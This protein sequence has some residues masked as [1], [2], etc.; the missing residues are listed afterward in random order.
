MEK[1]FYWL[2]KATVDEDLSIYHFLAA[3]SAHHCAAPDF[4]STDWKSILSLYDNLV[5]MDPSPL[6]LLNRAIALSKVTG[7]QQALDELE[8][9]KDSPA[10]TS[11]HLFYSTKAEF[12]LQMNEFKKAVECL[13]KAIELSTLPAEKE[14]LKKK[15]ELCYKK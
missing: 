1:G 13:E 10:L 4:E 15:L 2:E 6:I 14:L 11:Y 9:I 8:K 5:Q 7:A 12:Y 3:I